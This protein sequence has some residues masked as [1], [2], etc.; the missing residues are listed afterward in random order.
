MFGSPPDDGTNDSKIAFNDKFSFIV[1]KEASW[2]RVLIT[3]Q[4]YAIDFKKTYGSVP[5]LIFDNCDLLANRDPQV[6]ETLQDTAKR[7]IDDSTWITVF[8]AS[9]GNAPEQMEG[10]SKNK[11]LELFL[12]SS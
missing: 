10:L 8:V 9:I 1:G 7:A 4:K 12:F 5:V 11:L 3:F 6:L 2:E